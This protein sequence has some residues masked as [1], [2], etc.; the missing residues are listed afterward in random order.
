MGYLLGA[1]LLAVATGPSVAKDVPAV[2]A[3]TKRLHDRLITLDSHLDTPASLDLP[4]WS[5]L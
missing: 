3:A 1:A 5:I 2:P 4:G